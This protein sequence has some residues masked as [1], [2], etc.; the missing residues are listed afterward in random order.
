MSGNRELGGCCR[1]AENGAG[2]AFRPGALSACIARPHAAGCLRPSLSIRRGSNLPGEQPWRGAAGC[3]GSHSRRFDPRQNPD[4]QVQGWHSQPP[5]VQRGGAAARGGGGGR[6]A[7]WPP[8]QR[9]SRGHKNRIQRHDRLRMNACSHMFLKCTHLP[10][11][12]HLDAGSGLFPPSHPTCWF[13][14][15]HAP[16]VH[17]SSTHAVTACRL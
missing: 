12:V 16:L 6:P 7:R 13:W 14:L 8:R 15:R 3:V 4:S 10:S 17:F 11:R 9:L 1:A 5:A 2:F